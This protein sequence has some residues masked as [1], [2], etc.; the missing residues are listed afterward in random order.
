MIARTPLCLV[1][2]AACG[3]GSIEQVTPG[4][5]YL[6]RTIELAI[7]GAGTD[8]SHDSVVE[9][10]AGI[11]VTAVHPAS[12]TELAVTAEVSTAA[13][14]GPRDVYV[15]GATLDD[16][17]VVAAPASAQV[18]AGT[19]RRGGLVVVH[20]AIT[21]PLR[22]WSAGDL[23]FFA[24]PGLTVGAR[25]VT[26][27][28]LDALVAI[29][30]SAPLGDAVLE[31]HAGG[32]AGG[33]FTVPA[34]LTVIETGDAPVLHDTL[35]LQPDAAGSAFAWLAPD[36]PLALVDLEVAASAAGALVLDRDGAYPRP[37]AFAPART[38]VIDGVR[39]V[40]FHGAAGGF[41]VVARRTPLRAAHASATNDTFATAT[42]LGAPGGYVADAK[43]QGANDARYFAVD[44]AYG[45]IG[46]RLRVVTLGDPRTDT[47]ISVFRDDQR[48]LLGPASSDVSALDE[49]VTPT[50]PAEGR[51]YIRVAAGAG[52]DAA[53][54]TF[55][56]A[57]VTR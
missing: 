28:A 5:V 6:G 21:E 40:G 17:F 26:G 42:L 46:L 45:L 29:D 41:D 2:L 24:S 56:L 48:S 53:H 10:G 32:P 1:A 57:V 14:L 35:H 36:A 37:L 3:A 34:A 18:A 47:Q 55:S 39:G 44:V 11:T 7:T 27:T 51:Y 13:P 52:F 22:A 19:P 49:L 12:A 50:L 33:V 30:A 54:D 20:L 23:A 8:F 16:A 9:L 38:E 15:D 43:L 25:S 31:V 4:E